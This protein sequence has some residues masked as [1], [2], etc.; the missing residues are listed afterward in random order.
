MCSQ[1]WERF[2]VGGSPRLAW[3]SISSATSGSAT[4]SR[5]ASIP[6]SR[7]VVWGRTRTASRPSSV[8]ASTRARPPGPG[9]CRSGSSLIVAVGQPS[10]LET[11]PRQSILA[12]SESRGASA[13]LSFAPF[14]GVLRSNPNLSDRLIADTGVWRD[15]VARIRM[16]TEKGSVSPGDTATGPKRPGPTKSGGRRKKRVGQDGIERT[17]PEKP[18]PKPPKD[19]AGQL[20]PWGRR[21]PCSGKPNLAAKPPVRSHHASCMYPGAQFS[22]PPSSLRPR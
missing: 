8:V 22:R 6:C 20:V 18:P 1:C 5:Q 12:S 9:I 17:V 16:A 15:T 2:N 13:N 14:T 21:N 10:H 11:N 7:I 4:Q 19:G 3:V